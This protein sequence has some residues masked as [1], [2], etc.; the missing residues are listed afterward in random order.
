[1]SSIKGTYHPKAFLHH[2]KN[3]KSGLEARTK[4]LN[5]LDQQPFSAPTIARNIAMSYDAVLYHL[6]LLEAEATVSRRGKRPRIWVLTGLG[7]KR[8]VG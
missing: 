3:V 8:L 2:V 5:L 6:H 1:M 7:Q 4:I